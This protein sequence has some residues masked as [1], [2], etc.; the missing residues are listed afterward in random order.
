MAVKPIPEGLHTVTPYLV[1]ES[2]DQLIDFV[3]AA[4]GAKEVL[5]HKGPGGATMHAEVKIGDSRVMLGQASERAKPTPS[6]LYLYVNDV[7]A[8]YKQAIRAGGTSIME[9]VDMFY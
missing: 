4:F 1:V 3:K 6:M 2:V 8:T 9:P 5:R 7:D